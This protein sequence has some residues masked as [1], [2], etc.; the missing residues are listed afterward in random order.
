MIEINFDDFFEPEEENEEEDFDFIDPGILQQFKQQKVSI[1][2]IQKEIF[3]FDEKDEG[4]ARSEKAIRNFEFQIQV[5]RVLQIFDEMIKKIKT[6]LCIQEFIK[7]REL[8][9][10][11]FKD[12]D[13]EDLKRYCSS[14]TYES[15][16]NNLIEERN[17]NRLI[18][19]LLSTNLHLHTDQYKDNISLQKKLF[20]SSIKELRNIIYSRLQL[21]A[22]KE[23]KKEQILHQM[24][25]KY[26]KTKDKLTSLREKWIYRKENFEEK[27]QN[28]YELIEKYKKEID[29]LKKES[30]IEIESQ[31]QQSNVNII[32]FCKTKDNAIEIKYNMAEDSKE[33]YKQLLNKNLTKEK[34][35]REQKAK[36]IQ[37]LQIILNK[38]DVEVGEER[39]KEL[40]ELHNALDLQ[41]KEFT[42]WKD[43]VFEPQIELH[44]RLMQE[45]TDTERMEM[46]QSMLIFMMNRSARIL[47]KCWRT[48]V[49]KRKKKKSRR[50]K[51]K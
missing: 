7:D 17:V 49:A 37:G 22:P 39:T 50:G 46:E 15:D 14:H 1:E 5:S 33:A 21:T 8:M 31:I 47:Q 25:K 16:L 48:M 11:Y 23:L 45:K 2:K 29:I 41:R 28:K 27:M 38:Y 43:T 35:L 30:E 26:E 40:E 51:K 18:Q 4:D 36:A 42:V 6:L 10:K 44:A 3:N 20:L 12:E 13:I 19:M 9:R 32:D 34:R 24:W